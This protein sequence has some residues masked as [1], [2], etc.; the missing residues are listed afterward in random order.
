M[1][2]IIIGSPNLKKALTKLSQA[3]NIKHLLP[4]LTNIYCKVSP[5][6]I[7][8]IGSD[9]EITIFYHCDCE[10]KDT[11]ELLLPFEFIN[12]IVALY[13]DLPLEI[14]VGKLVKIKCNNDVYEIKPSSK[15]ADFP[16][17]PE[18]PLENIVTLNREILHCLTTAVTTTGFTKPQFTFVLLELTPGFITIASTDGGYVVFSRE[19]QNEQQY[20]QKLLLSQKVIKSL[21]GVD[22]VK[23]FYSNDMIAFDAGNFRIIN[24]KTEEKFADFKKIFPDDSEI[25][26]HLHKWSLVEAL[27]KCSLVND[28]LKAARIEFKENEIRLISNDTM[29]DINV[30]IEA[31]YTGSVDALTINYEKLLKLMHQVECVDV[32]F[33]IRNYDKPIVITSKEIEGYKALIMPIVFKN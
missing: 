33:A 16:K 4:V 27:D 22:E 25:N 23:A 20:S 6:K 1:K 14:E 7:E 5:S 18:V 21:S 15:I 24:T 17:L 13:K 30:P 3:I 29:I 8:F 2:K 26:L 10:A 19:F 12:K 31:K 32:E 11:F 9:T 28:Q